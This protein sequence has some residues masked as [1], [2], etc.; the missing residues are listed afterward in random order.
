[1]WQTK[2]WRAALAGGFMLA[3]AAT[4][5]VTP[6][7][8]VFYHLGRM[9]FKYAAVC[10]GLIAGVTI[11]SFAPLG[12]GAVSAAQ[13]FVNRTITNGQGF[14]LKYSGNQS[15][16]GFELRLSGEGNGPAQSTSDPVSILVSIVLIGAALI[17]SNRGRGELESAAP[18]FCLA[19]ILS[20]LSWKDHHVIL[21]PAIAMLM[22]CAASAGTMLKRV[23]FGAVLVICF[24]LF[25][26]TSWRIIGLGGAEWA[27]AHSFVFAGA[28]LVFVFVGAAPLIKQ[29][30][31]P[32]SA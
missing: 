31:A 13:A 26:L 20:P 27:D 12:K 8:L 9:R 25:N 24:G 19:V 3:L 17:A 4:M 7:I 11:L 10:L 5:K 29:C 2:G 22:Q 23:M 15:L 1:M 32:D 14:D 21:M 18:F 28:M 16:R 30:R 6:T